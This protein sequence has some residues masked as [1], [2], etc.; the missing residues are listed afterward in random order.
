M[1][2]VRNF[3]GGSI[4]RFLR[5]YLYV[6]GLGPFLERCEQIEHQPARAASFARPLSDEIRKKILMTLTVEFDS[7]SVIYRI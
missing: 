6:T 1:K 7:T 4:A 5:M 2:V 3:S